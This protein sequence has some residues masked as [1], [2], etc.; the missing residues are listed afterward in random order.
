VARGRG[1]ASIPAA[2]DE[3]PAPT[4]Q[5]TAADLKLLRDT[6]G[7]IAYTVMPVEGD[8]KDARP[9]IE[10]LQR[11]GLLTDDPREPQL[12]TKGRAVCR[13]LEL[14]GWKW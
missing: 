13:A 10:K 6:Y 4:A 7:H 8:L 9:V 3:T 1:R 11:L 5:Y 12:S 2:Q 14:C